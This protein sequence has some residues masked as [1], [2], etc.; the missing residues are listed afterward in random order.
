MFETPYFVRRY[1]EH[2]EFAGN[3]SWDQG[4]EFVTPSRISDINFLNCTLRYPL[5][6]ISK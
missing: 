2:L 3:F 1:V 5:T 4:H 6:R